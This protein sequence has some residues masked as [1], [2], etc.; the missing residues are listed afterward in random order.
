MIAPLRE[1]NTVAPQRRLGEARHYVATTLLDRR[2]EDCGP[3]VAPWKAWTLVGWMVF[4]S[5]CYAGAMLG[6]W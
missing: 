6:W 5:V 1:P 4:V 2:A 3:A